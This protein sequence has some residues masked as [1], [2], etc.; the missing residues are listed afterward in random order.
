MSEENRCPQCGIELPADAPRGLCPGCL[1]KQGLNTNTYTTEAAQS[2]AA[3]YMPPTPDEL[4]PYF[5]E[6]EILELVGRGGMGVVYKA[7]QKRL[8]RL[9]ALKILSPRIGHDPAFAQRFAREARAMAILSHPH[10]VAVYDFGQTVAALAPSASR[11]GEGGPLFYFLMEFIDGVNLRRLLD[12]GKVVPQEA[13]AIVPQI[14]DA[15]QFAHDHGIVHRDIKPE[16]I[17]LDK[18]GQVKIADFG[19]AKLIGQQAPDLTLTDVGQ[20]MGTPHYMAPEQTERPQDVDHRADIYSLGVVFYQMLTGELPLG[21]FAPPS[22]KVQID[23]RLDEVVLRAL[24]KEPYLRYQ[25]ASQVKSDVVSIVTT[26]AT[27]QPLTP[28]VNR[29]TIE[30]ARRQVQGPAI[31]L[32]V[33]GILNWVATP[34]IVLVLFRIVSERSGGMV[35]AI[36][37]LPALVLNLVFSTLMILAALKMKRLQWRGLAIA[38]SVAAII[39]TPG[40]LIGLPIGI[41]ALVVLSQ[42]EVR[43]AFG[44][45]GQVTPGS[46]PRSLTR[47]ERI[48]AATALALCLAAFPIALFLIPSVGGNWVAA[49]EV[50]C[51]GGPDSSAV[52]VPKAPEARAVTAAGKAEQPGNPIDEPTLLRE[53]PAADA[54][55]KVASVHC[56]AQMR[57]LPADNFSLVWPQGDLVPVEVWKQCGNKPKWRVEKPERVAVMDGASTA[58]LIHAKTAV[59]FP[60]ASEGAFDTGFLLELAGGE[61]AITRVFRA[62][63]DKGWNVKISETTAAGAKKILVSVETKVGLP[64]DDYMKNKFFETCDLRRTYRFDFQT[65]R[66]EAVDAYLHQPSGDLLILS[67]D[68]IDYDKPLAAAIFTLKLP[69]NVQADI[70]PQP[71]PDNAKYERMLPKQ[72][73]Q[74]FFEACAQGDWGE[75]QKFMSGPVDQDFKEYMGGLKVVRL[76]EPFQ[77]AIS[78]LNGD[79]FVPYEI[80]FKGGQI[81]KWN[82][83]LRRNPAA[84]RYI[85]D[86]GI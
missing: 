5:P 57:T 24:E 55:P 72:A 81:K 6:L 49:I 42:R 37:L 46:V 2:A 67:V 33:T 79:W 3:S 85:F 29:D 66:L 22:K 44:R 77:S 84:R 11:A 59:R 31:G 82:L 74:A 8:D 60:H 58:M 17:L 83:A 16:N 1:L 75:A 4:A 10:I 26:P 53:L 21:R 61:Y 40:N 52:G 73:A 45:S 51:A 18:H 28:V 36:G 12:A 38:A 7:R 43:A 39:V 48:P 19:L 9:V 76:G 23:V 68:R 65:R 25:Q 34:L 50:F 64:D 20:V 41:W 32:L 63:H 86:G 56:V 30:N 47:V 27:D 15:L 14:C 13:L 70:D 78:L 69:A 35:P 71:L 62:A 54:V 80:Q